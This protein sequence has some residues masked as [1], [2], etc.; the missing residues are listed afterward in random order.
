MTIFGLDKHSG[1]LALLLKRISII[2]SLVYRSFVVVH[3]NLSSSCLYPNHHFFY[4]EKWELLFTRKIVLGASIRLIYNLST[5]L[6][7][8]RTRMCTK[9]KERKW[10]PSTMIKTYMCDKSEIIFLIKSH[11]EKATCHILVKILVGNTLLRLAVWDAALGTWVRV[12]GPMTRSIIF[13]FHWVMWNCRVG[14]AGLSVLKDTWLH[15]AQLSHK[16]SCCNRP[17]AVKA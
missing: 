10:N 14:G 5:W 13:Q 11:G 17:T 16:R 15:P 12:S 7:R 8:R 2:A 1:I 9:V 3:N 6:N 4:L